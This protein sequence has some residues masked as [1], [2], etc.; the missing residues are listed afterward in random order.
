MIVLNSQEMRKVE[1]NAF[2]AGVDELDLMKTAGEKCANEIIKKYELPN[3][4]KRV[5]VVCGNGKNGGDGFVIAKI[6]KEIGCDVKIVL[7]DKEPTSVDCKATFFQAREEGVE[8]IPFSPDEKRCFDDVDL[9]VD[10]IFGIGFHGEADEPFASVFRAINQTKAS[11]VAVDVPSGTNSTTGAVASDAVKADFTLAISALKYA[12]VLPPANSY[13]GKVKVVNIGLEKRFYGRLAEYANTIER[14][15]IKKNF[16]K[17]DTN[18][19]KGNFGK[20]LSLCG[21]CKMPGAAVIS[22]KATVLSGAGLVTVAFPESAYPAITSN[23][24]ETTFLPLPETRNGTVSS[25]SKA[26]LL[27]AIEKST[28]TLVGCGLGIGSEVADVVGFVL[29]RAE[30]PVVLDADGINA[31]DNCINLLRERKAPVVLTPHPGEMARLVGDTVD[32]VQKHRID[33]AQKF[34]Q[35]L[36]AVVVLKGANTVVTD[37][38]S[39]FINTT[40]NP[41]MA[42]GG[43]GDMLAGMITSF[44]A[45]GMTPLE[46]AKSAVFIHGECGDICACELS[47]RGM[48]VSHMIELLPALLSN[49]E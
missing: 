17:R 19:N 14:K 20:V 4:G 23:L 46:A 49:Y 10:C 6:F 5:A 7:A 30:H 1:E 47:Q 36:G 26:F 31:L 8:I 12:H 11:V 33:L 15:Q 48:T 2:S 32:F 35:S 21:S 9:I 29:E 39:I 45:Q 38:K 28:V 18:S 24:I 16:S 25:S 42:K 34:A 40:G 13:C 27:D 41:G 37:G 44:I 22:A 43:T 3:T